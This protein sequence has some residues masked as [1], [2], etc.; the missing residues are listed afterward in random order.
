MAYQQ[1]FHTCCRDGLTTPTLGFQYQAASPGLDPDA[2]AALARLMVGYVPGASAPRN[3]SD[4]ELA[5]FPISL[6]YFQLPGVGAA[7]GQTV[8]VGR[9]D[10]AA[11]TGRFG[12][13]FSHVFVAPGESGFT[14]VTRP[15]AM[16]RSPD[17]R[18]NAGPADAE[19]VSALRPGAVDR[20]TADALLADRDRR[21]WRVAI[22]DR[23]EELVAGRARV[24]VLDDGNHGWAWVASLTLSLP[25]DVANSLSFDTFTGEPGRSA[26]RICV[27]DPASDRAALG[28]HALTAGLLVVDLQEPAPEPRGLLARAVADGRGHACGASADDRLTLDEF[29]LVLALEG[30]DRMALEPA[31][32][33]AAISVITHWAKAGEPHAGDLNAAAELIGDAIYI[34]DDLSDVAPAT[35]TALWGA[36]A[37][38]PG[39]AMTPIH[40]LAM[41][42]ALLQPQLAAGAQLPQ[43]EERE[44]PPALVGAGIELMS[45]ENVEAAEQAAHLRLLAQV[46]LVGVNSALDGRIGTAAAHS[47]GEP[48]V[49]EWLTGLAP[50]TEY[51]AL[52]EQVVRDLCRV[53][54]LNG[55]AL[56]FLADREVSHIHDTLCGGGSDFSITYMRAVVQQRS[57]PEQRRRTLEWALPMAGS[58]AE[59]DSLIDAIYG[60]RIQAAE[61]REIIGV[62]GAGG[63]PPGRE[64]LEQGWE[65]LEQVDPFSGDP[66]V[67]ALASDLDAIDNSGRHRSVYLALRL[68]EE[69][70]RSTPDTWLKR[71]A[72]YR[73]RLSDAHLRSLLRREVRGVTDGTIRDEAHQEMVLVGVTQLG[74]PFVDAYWDELTWALRDATDA[75]LAADAIACWAGDAMPDR[76]HEEAIDVRLPKALGPWTE[77]ARD[78]IGVRLGRAYGRDWEEWWAGWREDHPASGALGRGLRKLRARRPRG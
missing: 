61:L 74:P 8:Y 56:E 30:P 27:S 58:A 48:G 46:R 53:E 59:A 41:R 40:V 52:L 63:R 9:E 3:P 43:V 20:Q 69:R 34:E 4:A 60:D 31:D 71:V 47:L 35:I 13:Y 5:Q 73:M 44:V 24:V 75:R 12:N 38:M 22:H 57:H 21:A 10:R 55:I 7:V 45:R 6:R 65:L 2:L 64:R 26:A 62:L 49:A 76:V 78:A 51:R 29:A 36:V 54:P 37:E 33:D 50:R 77:E 1:A 19:M 42:S 23:L 11:A 17:W 68:E 70:A 32:L 16:W 67:S 18:T 15:I 72:Q 39:R 25:A 14:A 28:R 66:D